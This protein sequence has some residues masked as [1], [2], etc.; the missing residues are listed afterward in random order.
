MEPSTF[1]DA[2]SA[3]TEVRVVVRSGG[4]EV[5]TPI[6]IVTV[7][8]SVYVRSYRAAQGNWYK[9]VVASGSL[10]LE[11]EGEL[12][13]VRCEPVEDPAVLKDVSEAYLAKYPNEP[14]TP[15]MVSPEVAATTLRLKVVP[16]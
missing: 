4:D 14:E 12:V 11:L 15:D 1:R 10:P 13:P 9:H 7:G 5:R 6:W 3:A 16:G 2:A 8:P